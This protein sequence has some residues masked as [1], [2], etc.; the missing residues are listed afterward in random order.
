MKTWH[1]H[2][3][4]E[5]PKLKKPILIEGLP[6]IG[7]VG[8]VAV[9]FLIENMK[10]KKLCELVSYGMPNS[11]FVN[12]DNLIE[13]PAIEVY[14]KKTKGKNDFLFL[15]GDVQPIDE[16]SSYEFS[17][18]ILDLAE[19]FKAS[20]IITLGGIGLQS[21]PKSPKVYCTGN[22]KDI[23]NIYQKDTKAHSQL[24]GVVGPIIG[25][26]G[27]L[28]GLAGRR[29]IPAVSLLAETYSHPM[30]LGVKG[31]REI[32]N[33][34]KKKLKITVKLENLDKEIK[35]IEKELLKRSKELT[36]PK[37]KTPMETNYIG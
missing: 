2:N 21:V 26:S 25:V 8:K 36:K 3:L 13:L 16:Y 11:V 27:L 35:E 10:A 14:Y 4:K 9:D 19:K 5:K 17:D 28:L 32:L 33:I 23:V 34:L 18:K 31:A 24:Y 22:R 1:V 12:D 30:Y 29:G 20:E 7:N 15:A 37:K 6:G